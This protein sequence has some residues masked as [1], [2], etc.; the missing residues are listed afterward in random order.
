MRLCQASA[1]LRSA[2]R[3]AERR[4]LRD[5][6]RDIRSAQLDD[7]VL[8]VGHVQGVGG[9]ALAR[10]EQALSVKLF[11][12]DLNFDC[13]HLRLLDHAPPGPDPYDLDARPKT[14]RPAGLSTYQPAPKSVRPWPLVSPAFSSPA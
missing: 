3:G 10:G 11:Q 5:R 2:E 14:C 13:E 1:H 6:C 7:L 4:D 9:Q 8:E 12:A